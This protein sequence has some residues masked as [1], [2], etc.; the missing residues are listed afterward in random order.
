[1]EQSETYDTDDTAGYI[2]SI[3][4]DSSAYESDNETGKR[5]RKN[6]GEI[7]RQKTAEKTRS[8]VLVSTS[9]TVRSGGNIIFHV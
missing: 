9:T 4:A 7:R 1:M 2:G 8:L 6:H 3:D 5:R